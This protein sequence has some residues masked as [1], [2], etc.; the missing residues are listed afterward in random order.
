[1]RRTKL[2]ALA[3][4]GSLM[5]MASLAPSAS[6]AQIARR[7]SQVR[8]GKVRMSFATRPDVCGWGDGIN[9][10]STRGFNSTRSSARYTEDV[11]YDGGCNDGP[12]RVVL[13]M[14]GGNIAKIKTYVGGTWKSLGSGDMDLGTVS[15][16]EAVDYLFS[17]ADNGVRDAVFPAT[18]A[19][20]VEVLNRLYDLARNESRDREVRDQA[21]FWLS[22]QEDDKA[23]DYLQTILNTARSEDI[24]DKA[25]F[26]LSQHHSGK[27][28]PILRS[29]AENNN[30]PEG[31]REKAIFW[32]GQRQA[33]NQDYLS[34]LY[35]RLDSNDLKDKVIFAMSQQ[36]TDRAMQWL[37]DLATNSSEPTEMRKKALFWAGQ[38]GGDVTRLTSMY[39]SMRER[40]MKEQMIFV[41]S[42]RREGKALDKLMSIARSDPDREMRSKAMF[43]LG[44]SHDPRVSSFLADIINR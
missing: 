25:I 4:A 27:G 8:D 12:T 30:A 33:D 23:V 5:L 14:R 21:V 31:L 16:R 38:S 3:G 35:K 17:L 44:Q 20:S 9:T 6:E 26:G 7:V 11:V 18:L 10:G 39:D 28:F 41:L 22:Q 24:R 1:M 15:D 19:D 13:T 37:V 2:I 40:E 29:Y 42:Q 34:G 32:L 36:K 43:W